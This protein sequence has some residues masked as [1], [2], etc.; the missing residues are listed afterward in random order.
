MDP[1]PNQKPGSYQWLAMQHDIASYHAYI[2]TIMTN[3]RM[4]LIAF[5]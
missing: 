5:Q 2:Y 1:T 4:H 3:R